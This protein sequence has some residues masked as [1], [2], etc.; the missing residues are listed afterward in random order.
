MSKTR[1]DVRGLMLEELRQ[2]IREEIRKTGAREWCLYSKKKGKDGKRKR[3]GC[4]N[5]RKG[6][7]EREAQVNRAKYAQG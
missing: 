5:S 3:L 4:Y 1:E 7:E 6:A 2:V